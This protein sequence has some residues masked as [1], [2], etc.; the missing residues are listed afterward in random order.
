MAETTSPEMK[1]VTL[2]PNGE[3]PRIVIFFNGNE[4]IS[5]SVRLQDPSNRQGLLIGKGD[6]VVFDES[7]TFD[8]KKQASAIIG[9]KVR[10]PTTFV[11]LNNFPVNQYR[12]RVGIQQGANH[13]SGSPII[14]EGLLRGTTTDRVTF[15]LQFA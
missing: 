10:I 15:L 7:D 2:D 14:W 11:S 13:V 9:K 6:N 12:A 3:V 4:L 8:L 1:T 5:Y